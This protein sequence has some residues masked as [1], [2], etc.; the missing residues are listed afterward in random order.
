[1]L[2]QFSCVCC[3]DTVVVC[4]A[5]DVSHMVVGLSQLRIPPCSIPDGVFSFPCSRVSVS[6]AKAITKK[7]QQNEAMALCLTVKFLACTT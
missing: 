1:M 4:S 5:L 3:D 7:K 6:A 2:R